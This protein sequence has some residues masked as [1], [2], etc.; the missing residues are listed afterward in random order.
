MKKL[1]A[2]LLVLMIAAY[3]SLEHIVPIVF[4]RALVQ[5]LGT[6]AGETLP[7]GFM[8]ASAALVHRYRT[9]SAVRPAPS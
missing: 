2:G 1:A 4:S 7:M 8:L 9:Q 3:A 6:D 5:R